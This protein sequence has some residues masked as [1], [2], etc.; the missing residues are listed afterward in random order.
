MYRLQ[1]ISY[2][3]HF[4]TW[5]ACAFVNVVHRHHDAPETR[6]LYGAGDRDRRRNRAYVSVQPEFAD[7]DRSITGVRGRRDLLICQQDTDCDGQIE[8]RSVLAQ[9]GR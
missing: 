7:E 8:A 5:N 4:D 1:Q 2:P 6:L 9:V 3:D